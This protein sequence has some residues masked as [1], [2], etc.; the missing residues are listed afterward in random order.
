[1]KITISRQAVEKLLAAFKA[2]LAETGRAA[3]E[4]EM[5][6]IEWFDMTLSDDL[7]PVEDIIRKSNKLR[8]EWDRIPL[9]AAEMHDL[10]GSLDCLQSFENGDWHIMKR[11]L[12]YTPRHGEKLYQVRSRRQFFVSPVDTLVASREW[13]K[14]HCK[15]PT[16]SPTPRHPDL[17][18]DTTRR[19]HSP[20]EFREMFKGILPEK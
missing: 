12:A 19:E 13:E 2:T 14:T 4:R 16:Q 15:R 7:S 3:T 8:D 5:K 10:H 1:M 11:F 17:P 18:Q 20:E 6:M 9:T